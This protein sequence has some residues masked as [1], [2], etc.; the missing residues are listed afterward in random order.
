MGICNT[1]DQSPALMLK[2]EVEAT[3]TETDGE[4]IGALLSHFPELLW[5]HFDTAPEDAKG[6]LERHVCETMVNE[7]CDGVELWG[8][9][10]IERAFKAKRVST[11]PAHQGPPEINK[12]QECSVLQLKADI[13]MVRGAFNFCDGDWKNRALLTKAEFLAEAAIAVD[14]APW[15]KRVQ[16]EIDLLEMHEEEVSRPTVTA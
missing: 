5:E 9:V 3:R 16:R 1:K 8:P 7:L 15:N 14:W 10:L 12:A 6:V 13:S 11:E 2:Q 4:K